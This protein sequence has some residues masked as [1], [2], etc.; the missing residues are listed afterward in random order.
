[1]TRLDD[2]TLAAF[3]DGELDPAET[4][5]VASALEHDPEAREKVRRLRQSASLVKAVFDQPVYRGVSAGLDEAIAASAAGTGWRRFALPVA[6]SIIAAAVF[7]GGFSLGEMH[8]RQPQDFS[9]RLLDEVADYHIVYAQEQEHQ[10]ELPAHRIDEIEAWLG[11]RLH[12]SL[13]VPDLSKRGL[14]FRGARLLVVDGKPVA[15]LL[16]GWPDQPQRPLALCI[17]TGAPGMSGLTYER[18]GEVNLALWRSNA[19]TYVLV[20]WVD[21]SFLT[22]L[23]A[24]VGPQLDHG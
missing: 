16:Y 15:Q 21:P 22:Q 1:M 4:R 18:R 17:S 3:V 7:A 6:A 13:R 12:R 5:R 2:S 20:G 14:E 23:A 19:Y 8:G 11:N 10:V 9:A 24:D